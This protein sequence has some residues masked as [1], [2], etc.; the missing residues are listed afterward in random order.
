MWWF[1]AAY[2]RTDVTIVSFFYSLALPL[3]V[4]VTSAFA[5]T[6]P[7]PATHDVRIAIVTGQKSVTIGGESLTCQLGAIGDGAA[8]PVPVGASTM[9]TGDSAGFRIGSILWMGTTLDCD[10]AADQVVINKKRYHGHFHIHRSDAGLLTVVNVLDVD[11]YLI[12]VLHREVSPSWPVET[13]KAQAIAARTYAL[14]QRQLNS[15][16]PY[17]MVA[18]VHDQVYGGIS[19]RTDRISQAVAS[20]SGYVLLR[21]GKLAK[22]YYSACCGGAAASP[23]D[24]WPNAPVTTPREDPYCARAPNRDWSYTISQSDLIARLAKKNVRCETISDLRAIRSA[25]GTR[26]YKIEIVTPH[27]TIPITG[28]AFR[29]ALGYSYIKST[30]FDWTKE[31]EGWRFTGRGFGHGAGMCQWGAKG[32]AEAGFASDKI[33]TFYYPGT[34]LVKIY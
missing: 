3:F 18:T 22:A 10:S 15:Q 25:N 27:D 16:N 30:W 29:E 2:Q 34:Q 26:I 13:L 24:V 21:K 1:W 17:D 23:S 28:N 5:E 20:T 32:M 19:A 33:L 9:V 6:P 4:M 31:K 11:S 7:L 12:D 8:T 14:F